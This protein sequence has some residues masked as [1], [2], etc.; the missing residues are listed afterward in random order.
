VG[1]AHLHNGVAVQPPGRLQRAR[2]L[3]DGAHRL[4]CN[5]VRPAHACS[6]IGT[7]AES[8]LMHVT[9]AWKSAMQVGRA[10]A[11]SCQ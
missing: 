6:E 1:E 7:L 11:I 4:V 8:L 3:L 5:A 9:R 10:V 2:Q